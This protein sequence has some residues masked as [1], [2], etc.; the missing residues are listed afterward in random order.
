MTVLGLVQ[1]KL[2]DKVK[3]NISLMERYERLRVEVQNFKQTVNIFKEELV[4][5]LA[6][7]EHK[8]NKISIK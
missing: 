2:Q 3:K 1:R 6:I 7:F 4:E 5:I 8:M